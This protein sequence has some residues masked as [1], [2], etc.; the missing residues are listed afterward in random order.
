M[1]CAEVP[2]CLTVAWCELVRA[3]VTEHALMLPHALYMRL[4]PAGTRNRPARRNRYRDTASYGTSRRS[5][6]RQT[7]V[8]LGG[9]SEPTGG[10]PALRSFGLAGG[11]ELPD[12]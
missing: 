5:D 3:I 6:F 4:M 10:A 11:R 7:L 9:G 1:A 2:P 8:E 12:R